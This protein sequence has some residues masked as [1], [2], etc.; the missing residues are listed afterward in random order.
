[1]RHAACGKAY[2]VHGM[3]RITATVALRLDTR[4]ISAFCMPSYPLPHTTYIYMNMCV[5]RF[6]YAP[7]CNGYIWHSR[8]HTQIDLP[9]L[10]HF[11]L[12]VC[13][14][15]YVCKAQSVRNFTTNM[16]LI[17]VV[18]CCLLCASYCSNLLRY[19]CRL[20]LLL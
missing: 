2:V 18:A 13:G 11:F 17:F 19:P 14:C 20:L 16:L 1:M 8:I 6:V 9:T 12:R 4:K 3:R 7:Q 15:L 5:S 10:I